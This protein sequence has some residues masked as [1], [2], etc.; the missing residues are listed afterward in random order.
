MELLRLRFPLK[1]SLAFEKNLSAL[2]IDQFRF[3]WRKLNENIFTLH[4]CI[5]MFILWTNL[6]PLQQKQQRQLSVCFNHN[7]KVCFRVHV[8]ESC[9]EHTQQNIH[10]LTSQHALTYT[11]ANGQMISTDQRF[12][13]ASNTARSQKR[14]SHTR[15]GGPRGAHSL[16]AQLMFNL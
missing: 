14:A 3:Y 11:H 5:S 4:R 13:N 1:I 7:N 2:F 10:T 15:R 9:A 12:H 16:E 8:D 6:P